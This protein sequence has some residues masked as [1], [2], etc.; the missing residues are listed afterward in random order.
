MA[1][2]PPADADGSPGSGAPPTDGPEGVILAPR[3]WVPL[4]LM[5][6]AGLVLTLTPRW[7]G[8][9]WLGLTLLAFGAFLLLQATILRLCF[10]PDALLVL[11][12]G[13]EIRR[14]PYTNWLDWRLF[15][16]SLPVLF[17]FRERNSP[18]LLPVLFDATALRDELERRVPL[19]APPKS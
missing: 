8:A 7:P 14:F 10:R 9:L 12:S 5:L 6:I 11:R 13:L 16:P 3:F 19:P 17:Y 15:V 4:G 1:I 2:S 18:H